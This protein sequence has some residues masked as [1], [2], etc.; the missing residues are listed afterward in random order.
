MGQSGVAGANKGQKLAMMMSSRKSPAYAMLD[1]NAGG[2]WSNVN[3]NASTFMPPSP[4]FL[5]DIEPQG[6]IKGHHTH[7]ANMSSH[8][9]QSNNTAVNYDVACNSQNPVPQ[10]LHESSALPFITCQSQQYVAQVLPVSQQ[11]TRNA[12]Q[13]TLVNNGNMNNIHHGKKVGF[14]IPII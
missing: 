1:Q 14:W 7:G 9:E 13:S 12:M 2:S 6:T 3:P 5:G 11:E 8:H 10:S 4:V